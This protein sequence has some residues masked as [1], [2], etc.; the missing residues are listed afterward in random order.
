MAKSPMVTAL[1]DKS[2]G[3]ANHKQ[4]AVYTQITSDDMK[5][6]TH[7]VTNAECQDATVEGIAI[8]ILTEFGKRGVQPEKIMSLGSDGASVMTRKKKGCFIVS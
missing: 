4:L 7:F 8:V 5:P 2:S 6:S 3:V 1:A